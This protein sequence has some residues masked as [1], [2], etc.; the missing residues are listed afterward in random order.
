MAA[1]TKTTCYRVQPAGLDLADHR[2]ETSNDEPDRGVHV[3]G[4]L[5]ELCSGVHG[6]CRQDWQ[7]EVVEIECDRKALADNGDYEGMVL[8]GNR[9]KIVRRRAFADW[10]SLIE[11]S[12]DYPESL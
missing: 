6:W 4:C 5:P 10:D 9:G 3:F 12:R 11:W 2:S 8:V 7:P 1:T